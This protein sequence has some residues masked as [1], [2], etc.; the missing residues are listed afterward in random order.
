LDLVLKGVIRTNCIDCLDR[1]NFIQTKLAM[2]IFAV[3]MK[4]LDVDLTKMFNLPP[5]G[6][7]S[8][9]NDH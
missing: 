1:T 7:D 4:L 2:D 3:Q 9:I 6:T 5:I 8:D